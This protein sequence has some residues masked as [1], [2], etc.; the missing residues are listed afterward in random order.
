LISLPENQE[1][2]NQLSKIPAWA[3]FHRKRISERSGENLKNQIHTARANGNN[4]D[5]TG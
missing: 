5:N 2:A 1:V 3:W 4:D